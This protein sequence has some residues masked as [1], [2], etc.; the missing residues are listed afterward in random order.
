[1]SLDK[2]KTRLNPLQR[3]PLHCTC[4]CEHPLIILHPHARHNLLQYRVYYFKDERR[5]I[6]DTF[7]SKYVFDFDYS[8]FYYLISLCDVDDVDKCYIVDESTG[9]VYPL[10]L[11]VP[12][13]KCALCRSRKQNEWCTRAKLE[14]QCYDSIPYFVTLT[15][16]NDNIPVD[17]ASKRQC[18]LFLKRLRKA[19]EPHENIRYFLTAEYGHNTHRLHYHLI[20]WNLP[21]KPYHIINDVISESWQLGFV[22]VKPVTDDGGIFYVMKYM[23]KDCLVP[24]GQNPTFFLSSRRHGGIGAPFIDS[25]ID[26]FRNNPSVTDIEYIDKFSGKLLTVPLTGYLKDRVFPSKN[27]L[28]PLELRRAFDRSIYI[29]HVLYW[30]PRPEQPFAF[31]IYLEKDVLD[32]YQWITSSFPFLP[33]Y[34]IFDSPPNYRLNWQA[35]LHYKL[36]GDFPDLTIHH[37]LY[38]L[39]CELCDMYFEDREILKKYYGCN[40]CLDYYERLKSIHDGAVQKKITK[41]NVRFACYLKEKYISLSHSKE[42]F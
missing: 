22:M 40:F 18:Q 10:F 42:I 39:E 23:R 26:Y 9:A 34:N 15:Y 12:C 37:N 36:L 16:N 30:L 35:D 29:L 32:E 13:G 7:Y 11:L 4:N 3:S 19:F 5:F 33:A 14:S 25:Q 21:T 38:D 6:S 8:Y 24:K 1:M 41:K 28:V 2:N 27:K 20:L 17:G 31:G